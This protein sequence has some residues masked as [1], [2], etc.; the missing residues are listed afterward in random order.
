MVDVPRPR[1]ARTRRGAGDAT[2]RGAARPSRTARRRIARSSSGSRPSWSRNVDHACAWTRSSSAVQRTGAPSPLPVASA[3]SACSAVASAAGSATV[4]V[5]S[6]SRMI[7]HAASAPSSPAASAAATSGNAA[8]MH[9]PVNPERA[10]VADPSAMR[11]RTSE[12]EAC[13]TRSRSSAAE[14]HPRR[15]DRR[16]S[17]SSTRDRSATSPAQ[18]ARWASTSRP[19]AS[20]AAV[21][22]SSSW[23][24]HP[25][26]SSNRS[27]SPSAERR[28]SSA[29]R[30]PVMD[31]FLRAPPTFNIRKAL[32]SLCIRTGIPNLLRTGRTP[33]CDPDCDPRLRPPN[34]A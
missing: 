27:A 18:A 1:R 16:W 5:R 33:R 12:A 28:C 15:V 23:S 20:R 34:R 26:A 9:S 10:R 30:V 4:R 24:D 13:V 2:S 19:S 7:V 17:P 25:D 11:R 22:A 29:S 21:L 3:T 6:S 8:S 31:P 32:I 14:R